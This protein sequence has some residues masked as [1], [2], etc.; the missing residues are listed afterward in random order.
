MRHASKLYLPYAA[1]PADDRTRWDA[2]FKVGIDRFDDRGPAAQL[3]EATRLNLMHAYA[4][5]LAFVSAHDASLL[6]RTPAAR[7]DRNIIESYVQWQPA[8]CGN[9]TIA[10]HLLTFGSQITAFTGT[11]LNLTSVPLQTSA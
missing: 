10:R 4:R 11:D 2:A 7:L 3:A 6:A 5:F 8:S 1:W 9:A